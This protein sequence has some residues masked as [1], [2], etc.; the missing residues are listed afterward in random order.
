MQSEVSRPQGGQGAVE[1]TPTWLSL[2]AAPPR[3]SP[4]QAALQID[5]S[6]PSFFHLHDNATKLG[7]SSGKTGCSAHPTFL[8]PGTASLSSTTVVATRTGLQAAGGP[9]S[10]GLMTGGGRRGRRRVADG[11]DGAWRRRLPCA[12]K[13]ATAA[14]SRGSVGWRPATTKHCGLDPAVGDECRSDLAAE[15]GV[16]L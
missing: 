8:L 12:S 2:P 4:P 3:A 11:C 1:R 15:L 13:E 9:A 16:L 14:P 10:A 7:S 6:G 5:G